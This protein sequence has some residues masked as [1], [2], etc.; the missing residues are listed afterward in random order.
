V[1][2]RKRKADDEQSLGAGITHEVI[3]RVALAAAL[4]HAQVTAGG[5]K[6]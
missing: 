2:T 3:R 4:G 6:G 1:S 5:G